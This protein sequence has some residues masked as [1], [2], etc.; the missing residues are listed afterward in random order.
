MS[1]SRKGEKKFKFEQA[2]EELEGIVSRLDSGE[3][4]LDQML[5]E[6]ERGIKLVRG[7]KQFLDQAQ[8]KV[9]ML[10]QDQDKLKFEELEAE[11]GKTEEAEEKGD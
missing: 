7:C 8:K 5:D 10:L 3:L 4:G 6:F 2:L 9:E 1:G 11:A